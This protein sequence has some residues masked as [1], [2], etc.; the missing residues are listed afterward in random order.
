MGIDATDKLPGETSRQWG[1]P[2]AMDAEVVARIDRL[3]GELG[4]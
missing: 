2:I 4:L 3:W 1:R